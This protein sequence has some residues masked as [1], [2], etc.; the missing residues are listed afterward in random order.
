LTETP[1]SA[2]AR[3]KDGAAHQKPTPGN[4]GGGVTMTLIEHL[5]ELRERLIKA[6]V[7]I[8]VATV[9]SLAF[10][11]Q[12]LRIL[13]APLGGAKPQI[14]HPTEGIVMYFKVALIGGLILAMP[15]IVYQVARFVIPGLT[16]TEKRYLYILIPGAT[17]LFA[18]G[19]A[20]ASFVMLPFALPFLQG[21]GSEFATPG[22]TLDYYIS[23]VTTFVFWIGIVFETPLVV[24]TLARLGIVSPQ[25]LSRFRKYSIV[26]NAII[27][28]VVTPTPD[29]F[30]MMLVMIPLVILYELGALLARLVYRPRNVL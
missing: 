4:E 27:A 17:L 30:N 29:P 6:V 16:S 11:G 21:F 13:I 12:F 23:F 2:S 7:A 15:V 18:A 19:V 14:L 22:Y 25:Q 1:A 8:V 5:E 3:V 28:A 10:T 20:F 26:L 9:I 24:A